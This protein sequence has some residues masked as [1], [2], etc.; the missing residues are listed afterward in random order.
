M[1][2]LLQNVK[3]TKYRMIKCVNF[4]GDFYPSDKL[5]AEI[6]KRPNYLHTTLIE[7]SFDPHA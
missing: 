5:M 2:L 6:C 7:M 3:K 1:K 4:K